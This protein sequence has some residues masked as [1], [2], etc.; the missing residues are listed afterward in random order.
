[1]KKPKKIRIKEARD[2]D[3]ALEKM[4]YLGIF[5]VG[6]IIL[7][8]KMDTV[9]HFCEGI[10]QIA[11]IAAI[12]FVATAL[13]IEVRATKMAS[14]GITAAILAAMA[15]QAPNYFNNFEEGWKTEPATLVPFLATVLMIIF[16]FWL[17]IRFL[18]T[19][20]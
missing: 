2:G 17:Y 3:R 5:L 9:A 8:E 12:I 14:R 6:C 19:K 1:M 11:V 10:G 4:S 13:L 7:P 18:K 20:S 16:G 15:W